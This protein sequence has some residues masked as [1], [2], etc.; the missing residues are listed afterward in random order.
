M[1]AYM[2]LCACV[3]PS[4]GP[5]IIDGWEPPDMGAVNQTQII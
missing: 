4:P 5:I 2:W 1:F 3:F